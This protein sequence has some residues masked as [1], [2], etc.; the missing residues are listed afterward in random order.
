MFNISTCHLLP[1]TRIDKAF[2]LF[3]FRGEP[4]Y[5]KTKQNKI[6]HIFST[7]KILKNVVI[8]LI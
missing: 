2:W 7:Y 3:N 4:N 1:S 5:S 6:C 8:A